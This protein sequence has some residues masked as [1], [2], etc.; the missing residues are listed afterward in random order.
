MDLEASSGTLAY[1]VLEGFVHTAKGGARLVILYT[2]KVHE[3]QHDWTGM[4]ATALQ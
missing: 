3:P 4:I 1:I 2:S